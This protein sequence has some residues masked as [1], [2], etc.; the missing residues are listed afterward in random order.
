MRINS[1]NRQSFLDLVYSRKEEF[2]ARIHAPEIFVVKNFYE[3]KEL[4]ALRNHVFEI[5]LKT[6]A[7]WHPLLDDCPDYHRL[8]DNYPQAYVKSKMHSFYFHGWF[9]HNRDL[10]KR[11][12]EIFE[13]KCF[14]GGI[15]ASDYVG[16]MPSSGAVARVNAQNYPSGG[17][18]IAEHID[19]NSNY[20]LIQTLIQGSQPGRDFRSGG[21]FARRAPNAEK[22]FL[23]FHTEVG[24]LMVLSPA[25]PHGVDPIDPEMEYR[26]ENNSGKWTF[27]PLIVASDYRDN[28]AAKPREINDSQRR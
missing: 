12:S 10:F 27:L 15:K 23:D 25:I 18:Y 6:E 11:F 19:P 3:K 8:H 16:S 20:A 24:D 14:L 1:L 5:G 13:I 7:S 26:W 21:L 28:K 17:G 9:D 2:L 22:I 4:L